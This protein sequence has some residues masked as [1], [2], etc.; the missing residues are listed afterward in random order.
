MAFENDAYACKDNKSYFYVRSTP[1]IFL[2]Y[3]MTYITSRMQ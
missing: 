3:S 1:E 2:Q